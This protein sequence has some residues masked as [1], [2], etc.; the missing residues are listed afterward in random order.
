MENKRNPGHVSVTGRGLK[1]PLLERNVSGRNKSGDNDT[2]AAERALAELLEAED[3]A[4][5]T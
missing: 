4:G 3:G 5:R 2:G 1:S